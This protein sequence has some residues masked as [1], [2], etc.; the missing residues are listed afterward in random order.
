MRGVIVHYQGGVRR[1]IYGRDNEGR[2]NV[3]VINPV[4]AQDEK[5]AP[6]CAAQRP[7][8][9]VFEFNGR[10][11]AASHNVTLT[12]GRKYPDIE[13]WFVMPEHRQQLDVHEQHLL[14]AP[15][16]L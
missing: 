15:A 11:F 2:L 13:H 14:V 16:S 7:I 6:G 3:R 10:P 4:P 9:F 5:S 1:A 12:K 8:Y